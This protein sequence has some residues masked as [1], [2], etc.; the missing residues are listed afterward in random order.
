MNPFNE[1][2]CFIAALAAANFIAIRIIKAKK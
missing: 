1:V 2:L